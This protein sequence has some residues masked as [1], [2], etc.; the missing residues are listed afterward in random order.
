MRRSVKGED[1][2]HCFEK[3]YYRMKNTCPYSTWSVSS[4]DYSLIKLVRL[5]RVMAQTGRFTVGQNK[6]G[7]SE[8]EKE[9]S[10]FGSKVLANISK[11]I[12]QMI[13]KQPKSQQITAASF[14]QRHVE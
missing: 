6:E 12:K 8:G 7:E 9:K 5:L 13:N 11:K 10:G 3:S 2:G 1:S 4:S 14:K